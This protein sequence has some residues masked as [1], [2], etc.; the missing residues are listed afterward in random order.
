[1]TVLSNDVIAVTTVE[2]IFLIVFDVVTVR[3]REPSRGNDGIR[4]VIF[5]A[6]QKSV[7]ILMN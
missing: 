5:F 3:R 7:R 6:G 2:N 1:L 4:V